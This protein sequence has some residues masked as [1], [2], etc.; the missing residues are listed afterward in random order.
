MIPITI[1]QLQ[2]FVGVYEEASFSKAAAREHCSQP[3]LSAQIRNLEQIL[4]HSL[5]DRSVSG[6]TPTAAGLRFYRYSIAILRSVNA[7]RLEMA[8]VS[9]Q[10]AGKVKMGLIPTVVRGLLPMFLP[11]FVEAHPMVEIQLIQG[12]SDPLAKSVLEQE[13]DFAVV[14]EPPRHEGIEITK[15]AD[16]TMVLVSSPALGLPPGAAVRM[17]ELPALNLVMPSPNH[18]L[19]HNIERRIWTQEIKVARIMEMDSV[20]GMIDFV[21]HTAWATILPFTAVLCD[22]G[23]ERL[24][25]NPI[26]QPHL[27]ANLY[28]IHLSRQP[29]SQVARAVIEDLKRQAAAH[30]LVHKPA[31]A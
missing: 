5:F 22:V 23:S 4:E 2:Y 28:L 25:I 14:L 10:F 21:A 13:I 15:I 27:E 31:P 24:C 18:I 3:A 29:L 20:H 8:E 17:A 16:D 11:Q 1:R 19:R 26:S 9:G 12:F 6:V 7:A 30:R